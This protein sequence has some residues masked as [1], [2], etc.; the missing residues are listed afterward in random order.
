[1]TVKQIVEKYLSVNGYD[2]LT[3]GFECCCDLNDLIPC[4]GEINECEVGYKSP[5]LP[6]CDKS[7]EHFHIIPFRLEKTN[8]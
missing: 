4:N 5:C 7:L 6:D 1:M 2:G 8:C 3:N